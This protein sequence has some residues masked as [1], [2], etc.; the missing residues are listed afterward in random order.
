MNQNWDD[1]VGIQVTLLLL[2]P[3]YIHTLFAQI[4]FEARD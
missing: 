4:D 3:S 1:I 2:L